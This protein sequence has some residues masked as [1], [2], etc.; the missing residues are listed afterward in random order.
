MLELK[1]DCFNNKIICVENKCACLNL[2]L[3]LWPSGWR[4]CYS[5]TDEHQRSVG[6][7]G[8]RTKRALPFHPRQNHRPPESRREWLTQ[9]SS[10]SLSAVLTWVCWLCPPLPA[11]VAVLSLPACG[12]VPRAQPL[13]P[14]LLSLPAVERFSDCLQLLDIESELKHDPLPHGS[15]FFVCFLLAV[16]WI[17]Y[18]EIQITAGHLCE[19]EFC[20]S[21]CMLC[22][23][24]MDFYISPRL[25]FSLNICQ[26]R[27][28]LKMCFVDMRMFVRA[29]NRGECGGG[30]I[31]MDLQ[32][33]WRQRGAD[34]PV[35]RSSHCFTFKPSACTL[36]V[37]GASEL[38]HV[39]DHV[40]F[41]HILFHVNTW[42]DHMMN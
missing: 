1:C 25:F 5:D 39:K 12:V 24:T 4:S 27:R 17:F 8:E 41:S 2:S 6:G 15:I 9:K 10:W 31:P 22:V 23:F 38:I 11:S 29:V 7:G 26:V 40:L 18:F 42:H 16:D 36:W 28:F 34:Q 33:H 20:M 19:C 3:V 37:C 14:A 35:Q 32:E 30:I 21:K 13:P